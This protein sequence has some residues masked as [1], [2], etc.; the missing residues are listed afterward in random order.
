MRLR[1]IRHG[2]SEGN[3]AATLQGCRLDTPLSIRGRKQAES[4][5]ARLLSEPIDL[6]FASP[7]SRA[8]ETAE[9]VASPHG[10]GISLDPDL[11]EF[12]WGD[13][14]GRTL[15]QEME[16]RVAELRAR[17]RAG[18]I[19]DRAPGGESPV[20]AAERGARFLARL[21]ATGALAPLVV[22]HGR[23]NRVLMT[24]LLGRDLSR[25]DEIR[26]R[27]G[28]VFI[29]EVGPDGVA[30]SVF[31]DDVEHLAPELRVVTGLNDSVR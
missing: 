3:L 20:A 7:M 2:E 13:W 15:D 29:F 18:E 10:V 9:I 5:A 12:D 24:L 17:W 14:T 21:L 23:F 30:H 25:M 31:L 6:V 16:R 26:Q 8:R 28:S 1:L 27:N 11:V 19:R 22:A 4:L